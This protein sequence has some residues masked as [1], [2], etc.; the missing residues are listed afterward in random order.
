MRYPFASNPTHRVRRRPK[1]E[2]ADDHPTGGM[3]L[4]LPL[5]GT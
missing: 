5:S 2:Q 1:D 4:F 3:A